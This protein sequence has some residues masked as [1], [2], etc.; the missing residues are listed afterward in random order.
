M[1]MQ[2]SL[3]SNIMERRLGARAGKNILQKMSDEALSESRQIGNCN[4]GTSNKRPL[5]TST[6]RKSLT[7]DS[8][9]ARELYASS[10]RDIQGAKKQGRVG[11][12]MIPMNSDVI[13]G[14]E[15]EIDGASGETRIPLNCP[16]FCRSSLLSNRSDV[17]LQLVSLKISHV[18]AIHVHLRAAPACHHHWAGFLR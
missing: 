18:P 7:G 8:D 13:L 6:S 4:T 3:R 10:L 11:Q 5:T 16:T 14:I 9:D 17:A 1:T 12:G 15:E 2:F